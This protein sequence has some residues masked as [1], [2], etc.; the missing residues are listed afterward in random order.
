MLVGGV[1]TRPFAVLRAGRHPPESGPDRACWIHTVL[2]D[3]DEEWVFLDVG[4]SGGTPARQRGAQP[5]QRWLWLLLAAVLAAGLIVQ[6]N[7][8]TSS[9]A[10]APS[11]RSPAS[12]AA[13]PR[14]TQVS[15]LPSMAPVT[16]TR[17]GGTLLGETGGWTLF[18]RGEGTV[19]RIELARGEIT[20]TAVPLLQSSG[21][22][23]FVPAAGEVIIR[24]LDFVPGYAV[25]DGQPAQRLSSAFGPGGPAFP[26]PDPGHVWAV[27]GEEPSP[28]VGLTSLDGHPTGTVIR[29]PPGS[30]SLEAV[31]DGAGYLLVMTPDGLYRAQPGR[32][33]RISSGSL[34]AV[35][36]TGWLVAECDRLRRCQRILID[37]ATNRRHT[38]GPET[39]NGGSRAPWGAISPD[40]RTAAVFD[41]GSDGFNT[42]Q[43][44]DL[45]TG[46]LHAS[47][48]D[49][50]EPVNDGTIRW[51]PDSRWL[52]AV[53]P[54]GGLA[55]LEPAT[56]RVD[57]TLVSQL[58]PLTQL[59]VRA[60]G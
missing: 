32:V 16:V 47:G 9:P 43:L 15:Q 2:V 59:A 31:G 60:D 36:P 35:G 53:K 28:T 27:T 29:L 20:R 14:I 21:P 46:A 17:L 44:L 37:R 8:D 49:L 40:G 3:S 56:G 42:L 39:A 41:V 23:S 12:P 6:A 22:V 34:L 45:H 50:A 11:P 30:S 57:S 19:V 13:S 10:A 24:P 4:S 48:I 55:V 18:G 7:R 26:G 5:R 38:L 1:P 58:P 25:P 52:F 33:Q 51:S 54:L